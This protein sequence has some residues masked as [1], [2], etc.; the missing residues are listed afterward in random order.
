[1]PSKSEIMHEFNRV[2]L[3]NTDLYHN[4]ARAYN[5]PD[6]LFWILYSLRD[7]GGAMTQSELVY[8]LGMPKQTVNSAL[9][10]MLQENL[11]AIEEGRRAKPITLTEKGEALCRKTVDIVRVQEEESLLALSEEEQ[12]LLIGLFDRWTQSLRKCLDSAIPNEKQTTRK[13]G[14][15]TL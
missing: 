8:R 1:M 3:E 14:L 15:S 7:C 4:A 11:I 2:L 9:K 5:L 13:E 10:G 6:S 12:M